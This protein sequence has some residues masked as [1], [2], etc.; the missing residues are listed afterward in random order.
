MKRLTLVTLNLVLCWTMLGRALYG[1]NVVTDWA[2][3]VQPPINTPPKIP[4]VQL[5]LRAM[6]H[7]A[8]YD[9]VVAIEG[10]YQ[11]FAAAIQAPPGANVIAAAAT[12]AYRTASARVAP[13]QIPSL[14]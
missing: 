13:A 4:A 11:P 2:T 9:A 8:I 10:G 1:Q 6:V 5:I 3:I 7:I 14:D 12:A